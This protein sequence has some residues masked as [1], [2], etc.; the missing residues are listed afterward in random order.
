MVL[1]VREQGWG[2]DVHA[3]IAVG[4]NAQGHREMLGVDVSTAEDGAAGW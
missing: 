2:V 3:L 1:K 4:V